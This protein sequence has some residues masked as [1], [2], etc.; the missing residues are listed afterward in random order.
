MARTVH[1]ALTDRRPRAGYP[2][3]KN[4]RLL[5]AMPR[6]F[7]DCLLDRIRLWLF[8]MPTT[9]GAL[10]ATSSAASAGTASV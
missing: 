1:D 6:L 7:S 5:T 2:V 4:A 8:G 9:F 10:G 3:G